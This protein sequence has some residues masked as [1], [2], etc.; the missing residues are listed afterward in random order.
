MALFQTQ[1]IWILKDL[2][3]YYFKMFLKDKKR[4]NKKKNN[5]KE[6]KLKKMLRN[7]DNKVIIN[8]S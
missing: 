7:K 1:P 8:S 4:N 5:K 6:N 3:L 2:K